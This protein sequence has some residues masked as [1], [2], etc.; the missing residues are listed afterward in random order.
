MSEKNYRHYCSKRLWEPHILL[1]SLHYYPFYLFPST[2]TSIFAGPKAWCILNPWEVWVLSHHILI[3]QALDEHLL[4]HY[5]NR[6]KQYQETPSTAPG[7]YILPPLNNNRPT[8]YSRWS[9]SIHLDKMLI[10]FLASFF[11]QPCS[12]I[13]HPQITISG[14]LRLSMFF[15]SCGDIV[16]F[17][18]YLALH[19]PNWVMFWLTPSGQEGN[20]RQSLRMGYMLT[21]MSEASPPTSRK[22]GLL[23]LN[24]E[25]AIS[26][27]LR[28]QGNLGVQ[29]L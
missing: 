12:L 22:V 27:A 16:H 5:Q 9:D 28:V 20:W 8:V 11:P 18:P 14:I 1:Y 24:T 6:A 7:L 23:A 21:C 15:N 19:V 2:S 10:L 26:P 29:S 17:L 13:K 25:W 3:K 4:I